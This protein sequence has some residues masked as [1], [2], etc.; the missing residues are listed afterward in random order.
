LDFGD[1]PI[2]DEATTYP[3]IV[4]VEKC[5]PSPQP[6]LSG[7]GDIKT[8]QRNPRPPGEGDFFTATFT[9]AD[10]LTR[11]DETLATVGFTMPVAALR[12]EGWAL[13]RPET[14]AL[15]DKLRTVGKPL[16]EYVDGKIF[17]GIKTGLNEA[18]VI[19]EATRN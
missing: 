3:S 2:F 6:S 14:L 4:M 10:Q 1:L 18:F 5:S 8:C 19:D 17:Y 13:E 12:D 16:G 9:D 11:F 15:M 7:R